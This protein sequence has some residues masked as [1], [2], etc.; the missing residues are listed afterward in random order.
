MQQGIAAMR[1][2]AKIEYQGRFASISR[3]AAASTSAAAS[4]PIAR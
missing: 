2:K 4:M 1:D 3:D